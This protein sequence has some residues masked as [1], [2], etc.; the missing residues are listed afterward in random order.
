MA[1]ASRR[2]WERLRR[3]RLAIASGGTVV[4]LT[5]LAIVGPSLLVDTNDNTISNSIFTPPL[6]QSWLGTDELGRSVLTQLVYGIRTSLIVGLAA[7]FVATIVGILIGASSGYAGGRLDT[8]LMRITEI[9]QV[10]PTFILA[11]VIV[12]LVGPG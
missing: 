9:F 11:S 3:N 7:A 12:A 5:V 8:L 1:S 2:A 4:L 6:Q 10:M